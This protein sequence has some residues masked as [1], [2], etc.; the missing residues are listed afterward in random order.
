MKV[1]PLLISILFLTACD[2]APSNES[3]NLQISQG[4]QV[5]ETYCQECHGI[6][7][8]GIVKDWHKPGVDGKYPAPPLN[9][10]A[11]TWH[12]DTKSL[13][14]TINRGGIPLG[15]SMP[16]FKDTLADD[17]KNAVLTYIQSLWPEDIYKAWKERNG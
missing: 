1:I 7:A 3:H 8:R 12:H 17:E 2:N 6:N 11:H 10:T 9:G 15:G 16:A 14:G 4:K 5:F 13:L